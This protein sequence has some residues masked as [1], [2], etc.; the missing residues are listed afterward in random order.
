M[1][2]LTRE[3][4]GCSVQASDGEIGV[5]H[6]I[7]LDTDTWF[8]RYLEVG[9]AETRLLIDVRSTANTN[10][11]SQNIK[12]ELTKEQI[13]NANPQSSVGLMRAT[14]LEAKAIVAEDGSAG[15]ISELIVAS[16][17]WAVPYFTARTQRSSSVKNVILPTQW[18][19]ECDLRADTIYVDLSRE[20]VS[21]GVCLGSDSELA[22]GLESHLAENYSV[23]SHPSHVVKPAAA[24]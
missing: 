5:L 8:A 2:R 4:I 3:M 10:P 17:T 19:E 20:E 6:D 1:L 15:T 12:V 9:E 18:I 16:D 7:L 21:Y 23:V 11:N 14:E 24:A 13:A 22:N